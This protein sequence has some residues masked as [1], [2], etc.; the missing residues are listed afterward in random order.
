MKSIDK[1]A[2]KQVANQ[3]IKIVKGHV[4]EVIFKHDSSRI[5]QSLLKYSNTKDQEYGRDSIYNELEG[6]YVE[7]SKSPYGRFVVLKAL[8]Y[9]PSAKYRAKIIAE[10]LAKDTILRLI[11]HSYAEI[12]IDTIYCI[13]ANSKE[14]QSMVEQFYG[15]EYQLIRQND[16]KTP[17]YQAF[18][19]AIESNPDK[20]VRILEQL[21]E[22]L[23][24]IILKEGTVG[25]NEIVHRVV[26][27]YVSS[28]EY[29]ELVATFSSEAAPLYPLLSQLPTLIHT[30]F[31]SQICSILISAAGAKERKGIIKSFKPHAKEIACNEF[32]WQVVARAY[33][34]VDD[35]V[36]LR[37]SISQEL[38][39]DDDKELVRMFSSKGFKKLMLFLVGG[40]DSSKCFSPDLVASLSIGDTFLLKTSKKSSIQRKK[41]IMSYLL[42]K[43]FDALNVDI[44]DSLIRDTEGG[45]LVMNTL[46]YGYSNPDIVDTSVVDQITGLIV[47]LCSDPSIVW[48]IESENEIQTSGAEKDDES[49]DDEPEKSELAINKTYLETAA[50]EKPKVGHVILDKIGSRTIRRLCVQ[51]PAFRC[52]LAYKIAPQLI[53]AYLNLLQDNDNF[54]FGLLYI[55]AAIMENE[56]GEVQKTVIEKL[57]SHK[58]VLSRVSVPVTQQ[59]LKYL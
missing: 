33:D 57:E 49:D 23:V 30:K 27:D 7:L 24:N 25:R 42:P 9:A 52:A 39:P 53:E 41:E 55:L 29:D 16:N 15:L 31:G 22:N 11:K 28:L 12:V 43:L 45:N 32:G 26:Y 8:K 56:T 17:A 51:I 48:P 3:I 18:K 10:F 54:P 47:D 13:Y 20:R 58:S 14:R 34:S 36:L 35:T 2:R 4:V 5:I 6:H 46:D 38:F 40:K 1:A 50:K 21:R 19:K 59:I 44:L 37:N